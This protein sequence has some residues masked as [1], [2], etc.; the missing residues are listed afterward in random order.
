M[1][2]SILRRGSVSRVTANF[3]NRGFIRGGVPYV[4]LKPKFIGPDIAGQAAT[5]GVPYSY[6]ASVHFSG[7]GTYSLA[8]DTV[9]WLTIDPAT[10]VMSG[11]PSSGGAYLIIVRLSSQGATAQSNQFFMGVTI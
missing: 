9:P 1:R 11:T 3:G 6:D 2:Q 10:G 8:G 5:V 4:F 7:K